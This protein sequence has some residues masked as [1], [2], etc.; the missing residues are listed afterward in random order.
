MSRIHLMDEILSN[1]IAAGE[2]VEKCVSVVKELVEN[3]IDAKA[4]NIKIELIES[5][6]QEIKVVDNGIGMDKEDALLAFQRHATSKL[7]DEDDLYRIDT[8]GFRGEALPSIASVSMITIKTCS[9]NLGTLV[10]IEGGKITEVG[11]C[12]ARKGT[13]IEVKKLFYNT[14]ARLKHLGSLNNELTNII[15]YV[16]KIALSYPDIKFTLTNNGK[17]ILNT[18]GDNNLLKVI[19][20]IYGTDVARNMLPLEA[21]NDDYEISGYISK[22]IISRATRTHLIT[23]VN[24]RVVKNNELN[25][26][27]IEAY[28]TYIMENR[29][30]IVVLNITVDSSLIDVN[31]HPTKMDIKFSKMDGLKETIKN[32][33]HN[34][35]VSINLIQKVEHPK[36]EISMA[37]IVISNNQIQQELNLERYEETI[38]FNDEF[39]VKE[40]TNITYGN[41]N[42]EVETLEENESEKIPELYVAGVVFATY[43]VCQNNLGMYLI[44][45]HAAKE[46]INYELFLNKLSNPDNNSIDMLFPITIELPLNESIIL[47]EHLHILANMN[48]K[49][50]EFGMNS[51]VVKSHPVWLPKG[52]EENA[53]RRIIDLILDIKND[54]SLEKFNDRVAATLACK[55]S[56]KA[57]DT[58]SLEEMENLIDDLR[59]CK[60]PYNCPHGRPTIIKFTKYEIEKMF[61]RVV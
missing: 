41:T 53:I 57:N 27:I 38:P 4:T 61:K 13:T 40:E 9:E 35:L 16:N 36:P 45:Q 7:R 46:R 21:S 60:N 42:K 58:L 33:V 32:A 11:T 37:D 34:T 30:P 22:P 51:F 5:G 25:K 20:A 49:V 3:S 56:I 6:T 15:D 52:N 50:E 29:F 44:D 26:T 59:K 47:K 18:P 54:F 48:I 17:I 31:I 39:I 43:I 12:E 19:N 23:I 10:N 55:A 14:P 28:H 2:V 24:G 8:L 1:K